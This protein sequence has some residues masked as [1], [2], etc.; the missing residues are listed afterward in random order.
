MPLLHIRCAALD[1]DYM[2]VAAPVSIALGPRAPVPIALDLVVQTT[3]RPAHEQARSLDSD[4]DTTCIKATDAWIKPVGRKGE[5][6]ARGEGREWPHRDPP[7]VAVDSWI[8]MG[9][10]WG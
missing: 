1:G 10:G 9:S 6:E 5:G 8:A 4:T 3:V 7:T 2:Q